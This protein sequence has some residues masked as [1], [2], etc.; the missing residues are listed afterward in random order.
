MHTTTLRRVG[1]SV[2]LAVPPA[3]LKLLALDAESSVGLSLDKGRLVVHPQPAPRYTLED[4]LAKSDY[5]FERSEEE[6]EWL[7][8]Q[9]VGKELL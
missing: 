1:G 9:A 2:M 7:D 8:A 5:G 3:L 4:L 6:R